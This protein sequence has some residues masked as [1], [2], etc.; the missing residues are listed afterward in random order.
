MKTDLPAA[1]PE[2]LVRSLELKV[3]PPLVGALLAAAMWAAS[4]TASRSQRPSFGVAASIAA[5]VIGSAFSL[6]GLAAFRR[7]RTTVNPVKPQSASSLVVS[8]VY[9]VTRNPMYLGLLLLL[10]AWAAFLWS[11]WALIGPVAFVAYIDR[12]QIGPEERA[13]SALFG[14]AYAS[15]RRRVRRWL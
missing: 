15:Y 2:K 3:P 8:G 1:H 12:F 9:G 4:P 11:P 7:A 10:L 13:L 5:A 14:D 6:A